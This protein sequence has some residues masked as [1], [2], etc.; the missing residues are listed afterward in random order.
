MFPILFL[1]FGAVGG[2]APRRCHEED[3]CFPTTQDYLELRTSL[4]GQ[5]LFPHDAEYKNVIA[6]HNVITTK[7]PYVVAAVKSA[8]DVQKSVRFARK[9]NLRVTVK[10]SGHDYNGRST[11]HDSFMIYTGYMNNTHVNLKSARNPAG[12]ITSESGNTWTDIYTEVQLQCIM[13]RYFNQ[14]LMIFIIESS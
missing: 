2:S 8:L 6:M 11:A 13:R 1:L 9:H 4:E 12:E 10:C 3:S 7:Y 5:L 14:K